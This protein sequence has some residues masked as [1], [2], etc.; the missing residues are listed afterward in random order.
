MWFKLI[1]SVV[2]SYILYKLFFAKR[3]ILYSFNSARFKK[4]SRQIKEDIFVHSGFGEDTEYDKFTSDCGTL[5]EAFQRGLKRS[6]TAPCMG[7]KGPFTPYKWLSYQSV[8]TM[9]SNLGSGLANRGFAPGQ[10]LHMTIIAG[11]IVEWAFIAEMCY[12]YNHI[13]VGIH[14]TFSIAAKTAI[15]TIDPAPKIDVLFVDDNQCLSMINIIK[16]DVSVGLVVKIGVLT[17]E[18]STKA[19]EY[20]IPIVSVQALAKEGADKPVEH[21]PPSPHD[22]ASIIFT[23]GVSG[24]TKAVKLT[25][26]NVVSNMASM[27]MTIGPQAAITPDDSYLSVIPL[28]HIYGQLVMAIMF[29]HGAK[30]SFV[31][32]PYNLGSETQVVTE[33]EYFRPT[34]FIC[35]PRLQKSMFNEFSDIMQ[36]SF[37]WGNLYRYAKKTRNKALNAGQIFEYSTIESTVFSGAYDSIGGRVRLL[38]TGYESATAPEINEFFTFAFPCVVLEVYGMSE[39]GV[40]SCSLP[41]S[42]YSAGVGPPVP[43]SQV[44]LMDSQYGYKEICVKGPSQFFGYLGEPA[45]NATRIDDDGWLLTGDLGEWLPNGTLKI[46]DKAMFLGSLKNGSVVSPRQIELHYIRAPEIENIA[47]TIPRIIKRPVGVICP[48]QVYMELWAQKNKVEA[49]TMNEILCNESVLMQ[50][51]EHIHKYGSALPEEQRIGMFLIIHPEKFR[52]TAMSPLYTSRKHL[53]ISSYGKEFRQMSLQRMAGRSMSVDMDMGSN[54]GE[55][56][57]IASLSGFT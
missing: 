4:Q 32:M 50:F 35:P 38:F 23:P 16:T 25:H 47:V 21:L 3:K 42:S 44:K 45:N 13:L 55:N 48:S 54:L 8:N 24:D 52:R 46:I 51:E 40:I 36:N 22:I 43:F 18:E 53:L 31:Q 41:G 12:A 6:A 9:F 14:D 34:I 2:L 20:N 11:N 30:F 49:K 19:A 17:E 29:Y 37:L 15:L 28:C 57:R 5:Y 1:I 7:Y 26:A 10:G 33:L 39:Y 27:I 56:L